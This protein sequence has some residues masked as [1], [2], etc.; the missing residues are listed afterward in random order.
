MKS[1]GLPGIVRSLRDL[2]EGPQNVS[3]ALTGGSLIIVIYQS[4]SNVLHRCL[5]NILNHFLA[6]DLRQRLNNILNDIV[7]R[8]RLLLILLWGVLDYV[9]TWLLQWLRVVKIVSTVEVDNFAIV[10]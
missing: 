10:I 3:E 2:I 9:F 5:P 6:P 7:R 8:K 4:V 1:S